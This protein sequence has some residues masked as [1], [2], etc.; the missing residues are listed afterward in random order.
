M[1]MDFWAM[2]LS[3]QRQNAK[4]CHWCKQYVY[5]YLNCIIAISLR[6]FDKVNSTGR[7]PK[8]QTEHNFIKPAREARS[9]FGY[10]SFPNPFFACFNTT[11]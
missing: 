8:L 10:W 4:P 3:R 1:K 5:I 6:Y 7:Q 11:K 2:I 9:K